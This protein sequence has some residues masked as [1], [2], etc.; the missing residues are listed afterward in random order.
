MDIDEHIFHAPF[1]VYRVHHDLQT[2]QGNIPTR[3][4]LL[5]R[6]GLVEKVF[7]FVLR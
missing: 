5:D 3:L 1:N 7:L 4:D 6:N 2:F